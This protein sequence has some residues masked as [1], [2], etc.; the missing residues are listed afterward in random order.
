[1][2]SSLF[3][4]GSV[5]AAAV[6]GSVSLFAPCCISVMLPAYFSTAFQNRRVLVAMTFLFAAGVAT[7]VLPIA[8]GASALRDLI[9]S[10]HTAIYVA[11]GLALL[12]LAAFTLLGGRLRLPMPG[13][14]AQG[15]AGPL[16]TYSLGVF[17][18]M[19]TSCCAPVLAGVVALSGAA[20]SFAASLG[21]GAAY[22]FGMVAPLFAIS[23]LWERFDWSSSRLFRS[24]TFSWRLGPL[25]RTIGGTALASGLL[26]AL[27]GG[28]VLWVGLTSDG[29][30]SPEGWVAR[31]SAELRHYGDVVTDWLAWVP[32]W[33]GAG[34]LVLAVAMLARHAFR[35]L[36][37]RPR[38][39]GGDVTPPPDRG[40]DSAAADEA[41]RDGDPALEREY[42]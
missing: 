42:A 4:G 19:A 3:F 35:Q 23:L 21:L 13:A 36:E 37:L 34:L 20:S 9:L 29:M 30:P 38:A 2:D 6:A 17:S 25:R 5:V 40:F 26:L 14:R 8:L 1:M 24:R 33:L 7:V 16:S 15:R 11:M 31:V 10:E 39:G 18:G 22:V 28:A 41:E 32:G 27:I 12:A